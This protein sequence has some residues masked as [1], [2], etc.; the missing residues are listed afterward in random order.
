MLYYSSVPTRREVPAPA[1]LPTVACYSSPLLVRTASGQYESTRLTSSAF[2]FTCLPSFAPIP[3][4]EAAILFLTYYSREHCCTI[5]QL[6]Y[7]SR[8]TVHNTPLTLKRPLPP[9]LP[10][11]LIAGDSVP[12][13][14]SWQAVSDRLRN[15][16]DRA[17]TALGKLPNRGKPSVGKDGLVR[18]YRGVDTSRLP[19]PGHRH[20]SGL[21]ALYPGQQ[22][23]AS[24]ASVRQR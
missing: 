5:T 9:H 7:I 1:P 8:Q 18:E 11:V 19:D 13:T 3:C 14:E 20:W 15:L 6:G 17:S 2:Y 21:W 12:T 10:D 16:S 4:F 22:V 24:R 23:C